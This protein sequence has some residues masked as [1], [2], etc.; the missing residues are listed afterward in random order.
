MKTLGTLFLLTTI[1][2]AT[3]AGWAQ[4][5]GSAGATQPRF[6]LALT[7]G[8]LVGVS[9]NVVKVIN[10]TGPIKVGS[11][12]T[13]VVALTNM[14][15]R[16]IGF[17]RVGGEVLDDVASYIEFDVRDAHG[18]SVALTKRWQGILNHDPTIVTP[19]S[20]PTEGGNMPTLEPGETWKHEFNLSSL[21]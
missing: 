10:T 6:S 21:W 1:V 12:V 14:A 18:K 11:P 15:N 16:W 2:I 17:N 8:Q 13:V 7:A 20:I 3:G 5:Q 19:E 4:S 9:L